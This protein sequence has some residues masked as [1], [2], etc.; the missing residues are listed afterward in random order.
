ML[1]GS[2]FGA[3]VLSMALFIAPGSAGAHTPGLSLA[4]FDV[5]TDGNVDGRVTFASG[6]LLGGL[7]IDRDRDGVVTTEE[8]VAA[9]DEFRAF[10]LDGV[11]VDADGSACPASFRDASL[12]DVDGLVL[13]STYTCPKDAV[14]IEVTLY[15]LS[16]E[17]GR[18]PHKGLARIVAGSATSE[19]VLTGERR[20][21]SLRLPGK[22]HGATRKPVRVVA[23]VAGGVIIALLVWS[24]RRWREA[25]APWQ[26]RMP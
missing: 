22:A 8:V 26:N 1:R 25:R 5:H 23:I 7:A 21:I 4:D 3:G 11:E 12:T 17:A 2:G 24:S 15:Y 10:M 20:A 19:G 6:E 18:K 9:R 14:D 13:E 16:A